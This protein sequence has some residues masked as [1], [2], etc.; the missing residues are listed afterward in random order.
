MKTNLIDWINTFT[1]NKVLV[2][3]LPGGENVYAQMVKT[4]VE[5]FPELPVHEVELKRESNGMISTTF[6]VEY[7]HTGITKEEL[8]TSDLT[9]VVNEK[10]MIIPVRMTNRSGHVKEFTL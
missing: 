9:L 7:Q 8:F 6:K 3:H 1:P 10:E 5:K 2:S 4:I